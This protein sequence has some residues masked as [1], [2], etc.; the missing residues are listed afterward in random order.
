M[1]NLR[2]KRRTKPTGPS[3]ASS[4]APPPKR[5]FQNQTASKPKSLSHSRPAAVAITTSSK[6]AQPRHCRMFSPVARYEPRRP[7]GA[8][9]STMVGTRA[10][11]PISPATA[12]IA[13]PITAPTSVAASAVFSGRSKYAGRTS[14]SSETPRFVQSSVV[15]SVPST[16]RR[17]GTGSIP[18]LGVSCKGAGSVPAT[19]IRA[20]LLLAACTVALVVTGCGSK[21]KPVTKAQYEQQLQRLGDDLV[22]TGSQIGQ[23]LDIASFNQDIANFQDHLRAAS[24]E[25][26]GVQPPA[27]AQEPNKHLADAFHDLA[28]TLEPVKDARRKSLPEGGKAFAA[29]RLSA[30]AREGRAAVRQ[31]SRRGYDVGQMASL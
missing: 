19:V 26:K 13:F 10:S 18:Q 2:T 9:C 27:N 12:S 20:S 14:T 7:S 4:A 31:L 16:R 29:A 22:N 21:P 25:L 1:A 5:S 6:T 23:H 28:D 30:A 8:R 15:S 24:K 17:S 3:K 11:A